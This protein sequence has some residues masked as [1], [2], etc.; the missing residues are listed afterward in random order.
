MVCVHCLALIDYTLEVSLCVNKGFETGKFCH[1]PPTLP[2]KCLPAFFCIM[3][4]RYKHLTP[5]FLSG[6]G[7][8][9]R[10]DIPILC[11]QARGS[12]AWLV[13]ATLQTDRSCTHVSK[14]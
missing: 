1:C 9:S 6:R 10:V 8:G 4:S 12:L 5:L 2:S 14:M 13:P 3:V 11:G 7:T